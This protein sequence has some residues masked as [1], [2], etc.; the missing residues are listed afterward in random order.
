MAVSH[1][2]TA[3]RRA[4]Q[5]IVLRDGRIEDAGALDELLERCEEMRRLWASDLGTARI[6]LAVPADRAPARVSS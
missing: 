6:G 5:V 4:D 2:R 1:R 3:L